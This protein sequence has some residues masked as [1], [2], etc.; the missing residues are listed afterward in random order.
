MSEEK[1]IGS[2]ESGKKSESKKRGFEFFSEDSPPQ[3]SEHSQKTQHTTPPVF[4]AL[5][6]KP[7]HPH[8]HYEDFCVNPPIPVFNYIIDNK[9][10]EIIEDRT[11]QP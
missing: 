9:T 6:S 5:S 3:K 1:S 11:G 2:G 7:V 4:D 10:L 8:E